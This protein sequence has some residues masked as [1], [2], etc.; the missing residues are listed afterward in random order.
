MIDTLFMEKSGFVALM[1]KQI[2]MDKSWY[3]AKNMQ[4]IIKDLAL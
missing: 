1:Y 2:P 3:S 4:T